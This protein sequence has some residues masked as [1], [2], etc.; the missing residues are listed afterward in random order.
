MVLA[1]SPPASCAPSA[2]FSESGGLVSEL[3][4]SVV[5]S[6]TC[7][8]ILRSTDVRDNTTV[9]VR[10]EVNLVKFR[11]FR[12][13]PENYSGAAAQEHRVDITEPNGDPTV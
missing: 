4:L 7:S 6:V 9:H 10:F 8:H 2:S 11:K 13:F 1:R 5:D 12:K 3:T